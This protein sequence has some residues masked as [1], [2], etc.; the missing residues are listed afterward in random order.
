MFYFD[1]VYML[2]SVVGMI[3]VFAPQM[4]VKNTFAK[5]SKVRATRGLTGAQVAKSLLENAGVYDVR[6]ES[7]TGTLSDHYDPSK[8][9]VRLS[10]EIYH[11]DS[12]AAFGI[13]AHEVGHAIQ[14]YQ[15]NI[16]M[17]LRS[18]ILPAV[19]AGQT[20]GP[21]LLM[22]GLGLRY[23]THLGELSTLIALAGIALYGSVVLFHFITLPVELNA[24]HKAMKALAGGGYF[25]GNEI[26]GARKVLTAAALTYVAVALYALI[27]LLYWVWVLFGRNRD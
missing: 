21:L 23:F 2:I 24:S 12:V 4:L 18:G 13:A 7:T 22:A 25:V 8:K 19:Q 16:P 5:F 11:G 26:N 27:E 1:P 6:I 3:L 20:I 15:G 9:V 17:R 14:D 10:E